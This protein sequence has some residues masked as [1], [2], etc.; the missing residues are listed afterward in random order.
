[1]VCDLLI[2]TGAFLC[3]LIKPK[4]RLSTKQIIESTLRPLALGMG[5]AGSQFNCRGLADS[6]KIAKINFPN[7][8]CMVVAI[9]KQS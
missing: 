2:I 8:E 9:R 5:R 3:L 4:L 7:Y 1:M 6:L